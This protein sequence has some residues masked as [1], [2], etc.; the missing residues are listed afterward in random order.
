MRVLLLTVGS[1]ASALGCLAGAVTGLL[2]LLSSRP[3]GLTVVV[4]A[5]LLGCLAK[6]L[7]RLKMRAIYGPEIGDAR[8]GW[9]EPG[10]SC[11]AL[12]R[13]DLLAYRQSHSQ[14]EVATPKPNGSVHSRPAS[15]LLAPGR[16]LA[17]TCDE[18]PNDDDGEPPPTI[19]RPSSSHGAS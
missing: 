9:D 2:I 12:A 16:P 3:L 5:V 1:A 10:D 6:A 19:P 4:L 7:D 14:P 13:R 8:H 15:D 17:P 11:I 18:S